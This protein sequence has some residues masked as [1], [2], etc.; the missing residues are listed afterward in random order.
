V[1]G[2]LQEP[3]AGGPLAAGVAALASR[4][5][6]VRASAAC[7]AA[8]AA[9]AAESRASPDPLFD[10]T[11]TSRGLCAL[12]PHM[13]PVSAAGMLLDAAIAPANVDAAKEIFRT[14][15]AVVRGHTSE[16]RRRGAM[17]TARA[18][19][20]FASRNGAPGLPL[21]HAHFYPQPRPLPPQALVDLLKHPFCVDQA[22]RAVL[23]ALGTTYDRKFADH[24][25]FVRYA[26]DGGL[27]LDLLKAPEL[28]QPA[29][30]GNARPQPPVALPKGFPDLPFDR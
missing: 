28:P 16:T 12:A 1:R 21:L 17:A 25:E 30:P 24:W 3:G 13:E 20:A 23:D 11:D 27:P 14:F 22:R 10:R 19:G 8:R 7:A 18:A 26:Q 6:P 2:T 29:A 4:M 5:E 9:V 15:S